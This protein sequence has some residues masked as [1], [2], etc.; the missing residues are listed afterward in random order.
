MNQETHV[1]EMQNLKFV[2]SRSINKYSTS[3]AQQL[4]LMRNLFKY[5]GFLEV[6]AF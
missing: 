6:V 3:L 1:D 4:D 5:V 2:L